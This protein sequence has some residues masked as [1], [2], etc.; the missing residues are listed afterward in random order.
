MPACSRRAAHCSSS[1]DFPIPGSPPTSTTDPGT[2]PPP[3]TKSNSARPVGQRSIASLPMADRRTG[4]PPV[5]TVALRPPR[6]PDRQSARPTT[7]STNVFHAPHASHRPAHFGCSAP[8]SLQR[9]TECALATRRLDRCPALGIVVEASEFLLEVELHGAGRPV[10]LLP[11]DELRHT[12]DVVAVLVVGPV[13]ELLAVNEPHD[14]GVLL[15]GTRFAQIGELRPAVLAAAL[16][17]R[18]RQLRQCHDRYFQL[19]GERL[20]RPADVGDLL[21]AV[22][23]V[24]RA[25]HQLEV[26][27][28]HHPD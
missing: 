24:A 8:Q 2:M 23:D 20:E 22:F 19:F 27:D 16:L 13:V 3:K 14:V 1:V 7:S 21:L 28:H 6:P 17:R 5:V 10:A 25:R 4:G 18:A 12:L 11:D 26:I 9:N 15:D